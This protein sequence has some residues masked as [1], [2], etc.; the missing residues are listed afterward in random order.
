[1]PVPF[2]SHKIPVRRKA[3]DGQE[4]AQTT[5]ELP[6]M[7]EQEERPDMTRLDRTRKHPARSFALAV[8]IFALL[9]AVAWAGFFFVNRGNKEAKPSLSVKIDA[10]LTAASG[11]EVDVAIAYTNTDTVAVKS[12]E[13]TLRSPEGFRVISTDPQSSNASGTVWNLPELPSG[14]SGRVKIHGQ[15]LGEVNSTQSFE[16]VIAYEPANFSSTFRESAS[17]SLLINRTIIEAEITAP[18]RIVSEQ[19]FTYLLKFKNTSES[20]LEHVRIIAR[21]PKDFSFLSSKPER[22]NKEKNQWDLETLQPNAESKIAITGS[23]SAASGETREFAFQIGFVEGET[24]TPQSESTAIVFVV[25]PELNLQL[26][27]EGSSH[28]S[29]IRL[30]DTLHYQITYEN[31]SDLQLQNV[32]L[33]MNLDANVPLLDFDSLDDPKHGKVKDHTIVWDADN[34][35]EFKEVNPGDKGSFAFSITIK[36]TFAP[37]S[38]NDVNGKL[39]SQ[40]RVQSLELKDAGRAEFEGKSKSNTITS[41]LMTVVALQTQARYF[42]D[43]GEQL[44]VGPLPPEVGKTTTYRIFWYMTNTTNDVKDVV[45]QTTLPENVFYVGK[46]NVT[47]GSGLKFD[48]EARTLVWKINKVPSLTGELF[49]NVLASFEVSVTPTQTDVGSTLLLTGETSLTAKDVFTDEEARDTADR[50]TTDLSSDEQAAGKGAVVES[51]IP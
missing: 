50:L 37:K 41:K 8:G 17:H 44:G 35:S 46:G 18:V 4:H 6:S 49:S 38:D 45:A 25:K 14:G 40:A 19:E 13:A 43:E 21:L 28:D 36:G 7:Y 51:V 26:T 20:N 2:T 32:V 34:I 15:I 22:S 5:P 29:V 3:P 10:P 12:I 11:E 42:G 23:L 48:P 16:A 47:A 1:M 24:F 33:D 39:E 30:G 27:L 31:A 9:G